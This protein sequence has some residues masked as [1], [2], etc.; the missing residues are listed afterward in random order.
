MRSAES[1]TFVLNGVVVILNKVKDLFLAMPKQ[2]L[3]SDQNESTGNNRG[4]KGHLLTVS[5]K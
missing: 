1:F 5:R 4:G 2:I 3:H